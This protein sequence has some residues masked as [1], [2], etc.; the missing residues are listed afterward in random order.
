MSIH[1]VQHFKQGGKI[2]SVGHAEEPESLYN[3]PQLYPQMFPWLFPYGLG[4][5]GNTRGFRKIS[6]RERKRQLLMYHDKQFQLDPMFSLIAF[7]HK[8]IK[9]SSTGGF[10][11]ADKG[12]FSDIADH[13]LSPVKPETDEEKECFCVLNDLD[14]VNAKVKGSVTCQKNMHNEIW[15]LTSYLGAPSWFITCSPADINHPI[16]LYFAN[17]EEVFYPKICRYDEHICLIGQN[18]VAGAHF[19]KFMV[20]LFLKHILGVGLDKADI[21]GKT[22]GHY[23]TVEQQGD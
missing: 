13:L 15:A 5:L 11:L 6:D 4:G 10:L 19:F 22:A 7:N 9:N 21:Y 3:N 16:A 14:Y 17:T 23:G 2:L 18:S 1:T 12:H 8:Q 20:E